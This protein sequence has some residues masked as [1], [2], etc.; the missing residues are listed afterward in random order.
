M[1]L[2]LI[3]KSDRGK[4]IFTAQLRTSAKRRNPPAD[5]QR[6][7]RI[8]GPNSASID[9]RRGSQEA[10]LSQT[11][12]DAVQLPSVPLLLPLSFPTSSPQVAS[13]IILRRPFRRRDEAQKI[14]RNRVMIRAIVL[15][16]ATI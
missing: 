13:E 12:T 8:R 10:R 1:I 9:K 4:C 16:L 14:G 6:T 7:T 11:D 15:A 3:Y 2:V 5:S